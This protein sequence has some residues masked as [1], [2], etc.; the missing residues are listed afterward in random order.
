[1][2]TGMFNNGYLHAA[3]AENPVATCSAHE[4]TLQQSRS[5][6]EVLEDFWIVPVFC[7]HWKAEEAGVRYSWRMVWQL[8]E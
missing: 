5:V 2:G 4:W 3:E 1:M 8:G 6:T 7:L